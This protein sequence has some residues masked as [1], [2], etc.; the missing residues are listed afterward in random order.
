MKELL[1]SEAMMWVLLILTVMVLPGSMFI[2]M[3]IR[4]WNTFTPEN[5]VGMLGLGG[6]LT[7]AGLAVVI[8]TLYFELEDI[9]SH[10]H[11]N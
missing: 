1:K 11:E 7:L 4:D 2:Y 6:I 10:K 5:R 8:I 3:C 9:K